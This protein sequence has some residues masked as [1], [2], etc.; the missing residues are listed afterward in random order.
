[1]KTKMTRKQRAEEFT[2]LLGSLHYFMGYDGDPAR[3]QD[4]KVPSNRW[5]QLHPDLLSEFM[6][7]MTAF[8]AEVEQRYE[9]E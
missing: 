7:F 8:G 4:G 9:E 5:M 1:M 2:D 6:A 3:A